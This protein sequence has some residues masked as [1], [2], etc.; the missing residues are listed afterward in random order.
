MC[1]RVYVLAHEHMQRY[2]MCM[3]TYASIGVHWCM[4][5]LADMYIHGWTCV[6]TGLSCMIVYMCGCGHS[7]HVPAHMNMYPQL[8]NTAATALLPQGSVALESSGSSCFQT[9]TDPSIARGWAEGPVGPCQGAEP[10]PPGQ[11]QFSKGRRSH[12]ACFGEAPGASELRDHLRPQ[13]PI[14]K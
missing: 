4:N 10:Q 11:C 13:K 14:N 3:N 6:L 12:K 9:H 7:R 5:T 2:V 8:C 1:V